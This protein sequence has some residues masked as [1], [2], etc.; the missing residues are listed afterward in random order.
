MKFYVTPWLAYLSVVVMA[1]G[2]GFRGWWKTW[3]YFR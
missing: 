3:V 2:V 1:L